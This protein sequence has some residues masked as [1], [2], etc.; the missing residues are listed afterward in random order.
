MEST[1]HLIRDTHKVLQPIPQLTATDE[2]GAEAEA[3]DT[4]GGQ[5]SYNGNTSLRCVRENSRCLCRS[6]DGETI[7]YTRAR[8]KSVVSG[9]QDGGQDDRIHEGC[10]DRCICVLA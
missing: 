4:A 1:T 5:Q 9:R 3:T 6:S 10:R 7:Q 8:E 2:T